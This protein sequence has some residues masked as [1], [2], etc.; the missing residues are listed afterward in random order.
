MI[1]TTHGEMDEAILRKVEGVVDNDIEHTS[2][3]EYWSGD[4][5]VHRSVH[6][7]LKQGLGIEGILGSM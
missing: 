4:E 5:L 6:V 3:V 7:A 1:N 2:W